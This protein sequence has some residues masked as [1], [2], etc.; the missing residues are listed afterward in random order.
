MEGV[1][2]VAKGTFLADAV[3]AF[4]AD[5]PGDERRGERLLKVGDVSALLRELAD[6]DLDPEDWYRFVCDAFSGNGQTAAKGQFSRSA[7]QVLVRLAARNLQATRKLT[8]ASKALAVAEQNL[9][10][11]KQETATIRAEKVRVVAAMLIRAMARSSEKVFL[12]GPTWTVMRALSPGSGPGG[13]SY[14]RLQDQRRTIAALQAWGG[15]AAFESELLESM[16]SVAARY[17]GQTQRSSTAADITMSVN[18]GDGEHVAIL[19]GVNALRQAEP[20]PVSEPKD[21]ADN[22]PYA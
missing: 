21:A 1:D 10:E 15:D 18:F 5:M 22:W 14:D 8:K 2:Q 13:M 11:A 20:E 4:F 12:A 7:P 6:T 16:A 19:Q 3:A 17:S 9:A